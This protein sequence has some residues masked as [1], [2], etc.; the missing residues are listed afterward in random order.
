MPRHQYSG[1]LAGLDRLSYLDIDQLVNEALARTYTDVDLAACL[2]SIDTEWAE[3]QESVDGGRDGHDGH[4]IVTTLT[5]WLEG[6]EES[7]L[8]SE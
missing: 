5:V 2:L 7:G 6:P 4:N 8:R 1:N 3:P